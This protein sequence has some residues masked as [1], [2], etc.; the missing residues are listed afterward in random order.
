MS[1]YPIP[2]GITNSFQNLSGISTAFDLAPGGVWHIVL[3]NPRDNDDPGVLTLLDSDGNAVL[4]LTTAGY[5]PFISGQPGTG[6]R[7]SMSSGYTAAQVAIVRPTN[8]RGMQ[9]AL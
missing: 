9:P 5:A 1:S 2:S 4:N 8:Q 7:F 6:Y 3:F